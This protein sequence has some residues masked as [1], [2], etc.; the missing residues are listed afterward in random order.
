MRYCRKNSVFWKLTA[1]QET[2]IR[3]ERRKTTENL[4]LKTLI[5]LNFRRFY[6][7]FEICNQKIYSSKNA[8]NSKVLVLVVITK[9]EL[10][11]E[12]GP[13]Q[14]WIILSKWPEIILKKFGQT[15]STCYK[16]LYCHCNLL[17]C[18]ITKCNCHVWWVP[19]D[20]KFFCQNDSV[21]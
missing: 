15:Y 14:T 21:F 7:S 6:T 2:S 20:T 4:N 19:P 13:N 18:W 9:S 16:K 5:F 10:S 11:W 17:C 12:L 8:C 3:A 1:K